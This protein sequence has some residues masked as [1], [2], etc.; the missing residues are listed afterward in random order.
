[1]YLSNKVAQTLKQWILDR[2][3]TISAP[4]APLPLDR[5][6]VSQDGVI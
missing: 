6:F 5:T 1:M 2:N 4:V 3:F